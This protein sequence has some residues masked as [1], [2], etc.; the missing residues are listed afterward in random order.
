MLQNNHPRPIP[1]YTTKLH[2]SQVFSRVYCYVFCARIRFA[3]LRF[4]VMFLGVMLWNVTC[5]TFDM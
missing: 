2:I 3:L 1:N 4:V 5:I